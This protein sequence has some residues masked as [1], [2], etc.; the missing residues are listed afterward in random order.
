M[1]WSY[2]ELCELPTLCVGQAADLKLEKPQIRV[3]VCRVQDQIEVECCINGCWRDTAYYP[4]GT[5]V[6][7]IGSEYRFLE[8]HQA[9]EREG[10]HV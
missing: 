3:W 2:E 5:A 10:E 7:D 1:V 4:A 8:S 9:Y 6:Q